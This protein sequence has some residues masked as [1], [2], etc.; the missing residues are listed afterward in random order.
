MVNLGP[1]D[2]PMVIVVRSD[3]ELDRVV[4]ALLALGGHEGVLAP[5]PH[6]WLIIPAI[7]GTLVS[8]RTD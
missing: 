3:E 7:N 5:A 4:K 8:P 1:D 6:G 2:R